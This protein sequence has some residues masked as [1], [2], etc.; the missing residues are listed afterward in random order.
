MQATPQPHL[1]ASGVLDPSNVHA[2]PR[3]AV[4]SVRFST[5]MQANAGLS[6][7]AQTAAIEQCCALHG[8]KLHSILGT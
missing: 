4:G 7:D 3:R 6:L 1:S 2:K 8:L 5:D